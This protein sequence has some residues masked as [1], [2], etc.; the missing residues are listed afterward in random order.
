MNR[1][2]RGAWA[3]RGTLT[4]LLAL[5]AVVVGGVVV[6][7]GLS[8]AADTPWSLAMPLVLLGLV[9]VP[10]TGRELASVRRGEIGVARLRGV[11]G[12]QL[13]AVLGA[14]PFL[15]I[16]LGAVVGV[17]LGLAGGVVAGEVWF[18]GVRPAL[19]LTTGA[20]V[21][22]VVAVSLVAVLAGMAGATGEELAQQVSIAERPRTA[23]TA[24]VFGSVLVIVAA[25][26]ATYRS[27]VASGDP[28]W[29]VLAGPAL[30]GLA[31]GQVLV[32]L[33]RGTARLMVPRTARSGLPAYLSSRRL[34]RVAE[35]VAPLRLVV[36]A[37]VVAGVSVTGAQQV[38]SYARQAARLDAGAAYQVVTDSTAPEVLALT[39]RLDPRGRHLMAAVLVPGEG[40]VVA[41]RAFLDLSRYDEVVGDF[42]AGT[43]VAPVVPDFARLPTG[44]A[45][46]PARG[47]RVVATVAGV[48]SRHSGALH[49]RIKL[50]YHAGEDT[51]SVTLRARLGLDG[52]PRTL[53][54]PLRGCDAGCTATELR[55]T[56]ARGDRAVPWL[57]TRLDVA[58]ADALGHDWESRSP[59]PYPGAQ[60]G[61][62]GV[63]EGLLV[64]A[65]PRVQ[66]GIATDA[67]APVPMIATRTATW[68]GPPAI[69]TPGG[70]ERRGPV[71]ARAVVLPFVA[72]DGLLGDLA[73]SLHDDPPTVPAAVVMVLADAT[74]PSALL[75]EVATE[76]GH[77]P[78][79]LADFQAASDRRIG[80]LQARVYALMALFCLLVALL[81]LG[82]AVTRQRAAF[83]REV[84]VLRLLGIPVDRVRTAGRLELVLLALASVAATV[85]GVVLGVTFLMGH[86]PLVH[87]PEHG[88]ALVIGLAWEPLLLAA[89]AAALTV[90]VVG[91]RGR[92]TGS[93]ESRPAVMR[94][95]G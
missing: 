69:E 81:V 50:T 45:A 23:T 78:R 1:T 72:G 27:S 30:I 2:L 6:V 40:T 21:L 18:D 68:Q 44:V 86:L 5:V 29:V 76:A 91:W 3:R 51:R 62:L 42:Y 53:S 54:A 56:T 61:P 7:L 19:D 77:R 36:A 39:R 4:P 70:A 24:A 9:A 95:V 93:R 41:R 34:A 15:V 8:E 59:R 28:D 64:T 73:T 13:Y 79:S 92:S 82:A 80:A 88:V 47:G 49:P 60:V 65:T 55:L 26:V 84:A 52:A 89:L 58:G 63:A 11:T 67:G 31:V 87:V 43:A 35:A 12:P 16:V 74:T 25:L 94:E 22:A 57:I 37:A 83:A 85:G 66:T 20:A 46:G 32:W 14:E 17:G 33:V 75:D 10:V 38:G 90:L 71:V 48:S